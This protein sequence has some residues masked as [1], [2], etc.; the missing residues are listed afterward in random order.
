MHPT[1]FDIFPTFSL[2]YLSTFLQFAHLLHPN[3]QPGHTSRSAKPHRQL[4]EIAP[5]GGHLNL[6]PSGRLYLPPGGH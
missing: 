4:L 6:P 1:T 5:P 2:F 3:L